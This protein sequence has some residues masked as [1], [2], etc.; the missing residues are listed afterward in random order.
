M[1]A[2][3][4]AGAPADGAFPPAAAV[5]SALPKRVP[6]IGGAAS[7]VTNAADGE[8]EGDEGDAEAEAAEDAPEYKPLYTLPEA[9]RVRAPALEPPPR[10]YAT[11]TKGGRTRA[12]YR[13]GGRD[14]RVLR[15]RHVVFF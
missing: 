8:E 6:S 15:A 11:L 9:P 12:G 14:V 2:C 3:L 1:R 5:L 7:H 10:V 13:R 4:C